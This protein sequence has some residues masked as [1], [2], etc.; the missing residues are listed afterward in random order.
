MLELIDE[1]RRRDVAV[2]IVSGGGTEF[3]RAISHQLYGVP[4][5][6]VVGTLIDYDYDRDDTGAPRL[7]RTRRLDGAANEGAVKVS[8]IQRQ[9]GRRPLLAAGNSGGDREMLE[10][11]AAGDGPTLALL[12]DHDD[13]ERE[14]SYVSKA[15]HLG[16]PR[17]SPT[18][19]PAWGGRWSAWRD[20]WVDSISRD[21]DASLSLLVIR[22]ARAALWPPRAWR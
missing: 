14:F 5:E 3:V 9:L 16:R 11:A 8:N 19:A 22:A 6:A 10:W 12:V 20:D 13:A 15:E 1:L 17:R 7:R 4:P 2:T 21:G 18:S